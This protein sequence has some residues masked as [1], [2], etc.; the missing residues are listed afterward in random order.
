MM[1]TTTTNAEKTIT[2]S[3]KIR[4]VIKN[5]TTGG[6]ICNRLLHIVIFLTLAGAREYALKNKLNADSYRI[7]SVWITERGGKVTN[8]SSGLQAD[9]DGF[10]EQ[11]V[12]S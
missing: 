3:I 10:F 8:V 5:I 7:E 4:Y 6:L 12:Q 2:P 1:N 11:E 9:S